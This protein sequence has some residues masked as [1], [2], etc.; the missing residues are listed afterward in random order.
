MSES[1]GSSEIMSFI[2]GAVVGAAAALLFA[3]YAGNETRRR[4]GETARR[5]QGNAKSTLHGMKE[6]IDHAAEDVREAVAEG[7][8][9]YSRARSSRA[10]Q[11]E[12]PLSRE[13]L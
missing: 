11:A 2:A 8:D 7:R 9:A 4:L 3:P 12:T 5:V 13:T 10:A 6:R 1:R